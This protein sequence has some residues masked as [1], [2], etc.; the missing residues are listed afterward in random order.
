MPST[1]YL[2]AA[3]KSSGK[4]IVSLGL[5][6]AFR[7]QSLSLQAFKKGPDYIDPIWLSQASGKPCYNLDFYNMSAEEISALY[8]QYAS[9][10]DVGI[11]EGNKGLFDGMQ[12]AGGDANADLAKLLNTPVILVLDAT[13]I[14]RGIAPLVSGYQAFDKE[15]NIAGVIIN[16]VAGEPSSIKTD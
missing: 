5:C 4:T 15:L 3:H 16:K 6:A 12:V 14:S 13:G 10:S 11:I 2:S 9:Q 7:Q 8:A 1:F